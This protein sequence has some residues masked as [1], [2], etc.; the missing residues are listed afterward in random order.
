L[1]ASTTVTQI[2]L[3][4]SLD[5]LFKPGLHRETLAFLNREDSLFCSIEEQRENAKFY[6]EMAG[7]VG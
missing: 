6:S 1:L 5:K 4:D 3:D 2:A 7:Y